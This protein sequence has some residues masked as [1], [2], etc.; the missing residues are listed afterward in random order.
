MTS[1]PDLGPPRLFILCVVLSQDLGYS[2][3]SRDIYSIS[4]TLQDLS[5]LTPSPARVTA[6]ASKLG[7]ARLAPSTP[8][9]VLGG[10]LSEMEIY[11]G[12]IPGQ[13]L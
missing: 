8:P 4:E 13:N 3:C 2:R 7:T 1:G 11:P 10:K 6:A 9:S 12:F 5:R